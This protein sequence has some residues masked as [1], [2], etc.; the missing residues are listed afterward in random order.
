[1]KFGIAFS[2]VL[3]VLMFMVGSFWISTQNRA[4]G[5]ENLHG[6]KQK[7]NTSQF[8]NMFK[9]IAQSAKVTDMQKEAFKEC[10]KA[11]VDGRGAGGGSIFKAVNEAVPNLDQSN[12]ANLINIVNSARDS[13]TRNQKELLDIEREHNNLRTMFPSSLVC[14]SRPALK[15]IIITSSRTEETFRTGQDNDIDLIPNQTKAEK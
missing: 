14:G 10:I 3:V 15:S 7:D 13:W 12:F 5:L 4:V 8:D 1:M 9:K 11:Y 6:A 2:V